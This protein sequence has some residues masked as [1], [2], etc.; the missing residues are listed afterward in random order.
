MFHNIF[1]LIVEYVVHQILAPL[2]SADFI[3]GA[4]GWP[5]EGCVRVNGRELRQSME[6]DPYCNTLPHRD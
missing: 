1:F 3:H 6:R 4:I 5:Q 2:K